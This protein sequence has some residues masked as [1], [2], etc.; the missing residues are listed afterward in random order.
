MADKE[1]F[2]FMKSGFNNLDRK[3]DTLENVTAIV[4]MRN[5]TTLDSTFPFLAASP[6]KQRSRILC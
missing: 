2:T 1:D 6:T 5:S 3:D 4:W